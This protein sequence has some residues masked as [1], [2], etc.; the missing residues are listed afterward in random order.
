MNQK[1]PNRPLRVFEKVLEGGLGRGNLGVIMSRHGTGKV[2]VMTSIAIDHAMNGVNTLH[3]VFGKSVS[4]VRAYDDEVLNQMIEAHGLNDRAEIV[5]RVERHKQIY[6]YRSGDFSVQRLR[7][8]LEF[9]SEHA[10][11]RPGLIEIHGWPDFDTVDPKEVAALKALAKEWDCEVWVT[12]HTHREHETTHQIPE[13]VKRF[14]SLIEVMIAL[15]PNGPHVNVRFVKVHGK[16]SKEN[17]R[18]EFDP[19]AMIIRWS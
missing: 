19:K 16:A 9:L 6:T 7:G 2:A 4:E 13:G 10:Q 15:E 11:F 12:A 8:T 3:A 5:A 18:L 17:V 1:E 14:E